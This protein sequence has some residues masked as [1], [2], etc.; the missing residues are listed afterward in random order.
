[1][2]TANQPDAELCLVDV[3]APSWTI[4]LDCACGFRNV[5]RLQRT[6]RL[7]GVRRWRVV[8]RKWLPVRNSYT[9]DRWAREKRHSAKR[10]PDVAHC[11]EC[12][13]PRC[14][15]THLVRDDRLY[16][17]LRGAEQYGIRTLVLGVDL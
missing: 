11:F 14:K 10:G 7:D 13:A 6:L 16:W 9:H 17:A 3:G 2:A 8:Q 1:V 12:P 15:R 5:V 4:R